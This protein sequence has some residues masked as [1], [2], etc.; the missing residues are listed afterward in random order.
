MMKQLE[1]VYLMN[2]VLHFP[3]YYDIQTFIQINKKCFSAVDDLKIN[4]WFMTP[5]SITTFHKHFTPETMNCNSF[6]SSEYELMERCTFLRNPE[7]IVKE[8]TTDQIIQLLPKITSIVLKESNFKQTTLILNNATQLTSLRHINGN[9][10]MIH[11]FCKRCYVDDFFQLSLLNKIQIEITD[12]DMKCAYKSIEL[13]KEMKQWIRNRNIDVYV[14]GYYNFFTQEEMKEFKELG[15]QFRFKVLTQIQLEECWKYY[16]SPSYSVIIDG[17]YDCNCLN[18]II[19]KRLP[20]I[21]NI[22]MEN[23]NELKNEIERVQGYTYQQEDIR[24][25]N[26]NIPKCIKEVKLYKHNPIVVEN[27]L[28]V[29]IPIPI[30]CKHLETIKLVNC[31]NVMITQP[32][33]RLKYLLIHESENISIQTSNDK[34]QFGIPNLETLKIIR[35]DSVTVHVFS[36]KLK[37]L[38]IEGGERIYIHGSIDTVETI[39]FFFINQL[40]IPYCSFEGKK[41]HIFYCKTIQ[42]IDKNEKRSPL[43]YLSLSLEQF[44]NLS[45]E[46]ITLPTH[47]PSLLDKKFLSHFFVQ[48][49]FFTS[50]ERLIQN[51]NTYR[52]DKQP[53]EFYYSIDMLLSNEFLSWRRNT[54]QFFLQNEQHEWECYE[55]SIRYFEVSIKGLAIICI[56]LYD[57]YQMTEHR[58]SYSTFI[59]LENYTIGYYSETGCLQVN[60]K[61]MDYASPYANKPNNID[62]IGCG[63]NCKTKEVFFTKNGELL[64][65]HYFPYSNLTAAIS[66]YILDELT[67]NYGNEPFVFDLKY[68]IQTNTLFRRMINNCVIY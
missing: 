66:V 14:I 60:G 27:T 67:I 25:I 50:S 31:R 51:G 62:V 2:V 63:Y 4:P 52:M 17:F 9:V 22:L 39:S 45:M 36:K 13:M 46:C 44:N 5:H 23:S 40:I 35:S 61:K 18:E 32:L 53:K 29:I 24:N 26:W 7:F 59:G 56:G 6:K 3:L 54:M 48:T 16:V 30:N 42:C 11:E 12:E 55:A 20:H 34:K 58:P 1:R 41:V 10:R 8:E 57:P 49:P 47:I 19:E 28:N 43:E 33:K 65:S 64:P 37:T 68:H 38:T 15:F 21:A